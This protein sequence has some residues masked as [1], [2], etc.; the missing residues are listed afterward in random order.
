MRAPPA[1]SG[2]GAS[3]DSDKESLA[4]RVV[5]VES[6]LPIRS[7]SN[8]D[9]ANLRAIWWRHAALGHHLPAERGIIVIDGGV[10]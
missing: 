9:V 4:G 2:G 3:L 10:P 7:L 1:C 6:T 8:A 5:A